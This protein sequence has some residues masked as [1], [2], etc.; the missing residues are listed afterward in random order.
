MVWD[1]RD[2]AS[3]WSGPSAWQMGLPGTADWKGAQWIAYERMPDSLRIVPGIHGGGD[4]QSGP[5]KNILPLLRKEF[6]IRKTVRKAT[7]FVAGLGHF[8]FS[9]NGKKAGDHFLDAGWTQYSNN[10]LYVTFDITALLKEGG[11]ALGM[12]LGNGFYYTPRE[13]YRKI[14]IAYGYPKMICRI[15]VEYTDG[16]AEDIISDATWKAC[17]GPVTFSSIY[18]GEDYDATLEQTGWNSPSFNDRLW[19][20]AIIVDGPPVL[21]AQTADPLKIKDSFSV[22]RITAPGP[23][24]WVYDFGQNAS[25][26]FRIKVKGKKQDQV[27]FRPAELVTDDG[28]ITQD[29][30]GTPV[31][32]RYTLKGD[33]AEAWQPRF[34]YYG[35][36]YIQVE[37]AVPKGAPNPQGLPVIMEIVSLHT[38]NAAARVGHFSCSNDLFNRTATLIDWAVRSNMVSVFTDCPHR[39]KLGWLEEAHLMGSSVQYNYHIAG[40]G[41]KVVKDMIAAQ[42]AEGLVPNIAPEYV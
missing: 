1:D 16:S 28:L 17:P 34:T 8:D 24:V 5:G 10:A 30:V 4:P 36:R 25:G 38:R 20:K 31:Y 2:V 37:G 14:T 11:N 32:F 6:E 18:G 15:V 23:S 7:A 40:L 35:F 41:R 22:K 33:T 27:T 3:Q 12:M 26:I 39:E 9:V 29:A 19:R 13:R 21:S 42:T